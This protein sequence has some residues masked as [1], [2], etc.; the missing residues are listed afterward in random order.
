MRFLL[1]ILLFPFLSFGQDIPIDYGTGSSTGASVQRSAIDSAGGGGA[2]FTVHINT[3]GTTVTKIVVVLDN[4]G[5]TTTTVKNTFGN[6]FILAKENTAHSIQIW[7]LD[8]MANNSAT[9]II[10]IA[11]SGGFGMAAVY[12]LTG[13]VASGFDGTPT[14]NFLNPT[15]SIQ[16]GSSTAVA[17]GISFAGLFYESA[18]AAAINLSYGLDYN[19][20]EVAG[21][22]Y[23]FASAH[24][25]PTLAQGYNPTY[26]WVTAV[27]AAMV[28]VNFH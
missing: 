10:S 22:N 28:L 6:S 19:F 1:I 3:A 27:D 24:L 4:G 26:T 5:G 25:A 13:T 21:K 15:T 20:P 2:N 18:S 9:D 7:Y 8:N 14:A 12:V 11:N 17:N 16:A 23:G